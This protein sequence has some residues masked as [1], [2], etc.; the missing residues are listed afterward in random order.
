[1]YTCIYAYIYIYMHPSGVHEGRCLAK[2]ALA[3]RVLLLYDYYDYFY[4][5]VILLLL[6]LL[7]S[8]SLSLPNPLSFSN[9]CVSAICAGPLEMQ[10]SLLP[11]SKARA[12][13]LQCKTLEEQT[14]G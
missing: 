3:I 6:L 7:L 14:S 2:G 9:L 11:P 13:E 10:P 8:L 5:I 12:K 1:M 4:Y